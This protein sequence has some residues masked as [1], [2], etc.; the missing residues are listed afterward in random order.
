M[1]LV[2][3]C[4]I[5]ISLPSKSGA[6][7]WLGRSWAHMGSRSQARAVVALGS[8]YGIGIS[9]P[10]GMV[11]SRLLECGSAAL[12]G[13]LHGGPTLSGAGISEVGPVCRSVVGESA[14][15]S[16][17]ELILVIIGFTGQPGSQCVLELKDAIGINRF[18]ELEE[19][20]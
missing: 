4:G 17:A 10:R 20:G 2:S 5:G 19:G 15:K 18:V 12:H 7:E 16:T 8:C 11:V 6:G 9:F 3:R 13:G 14:A 1:A